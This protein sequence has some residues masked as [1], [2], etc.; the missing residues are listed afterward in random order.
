MSLS[1]LKDVDREILKS[2]DDKDLLKICGLNRKTW[3][4]VCDDN[5]LRRRITGKYPGIEKYK[6]EGESWKRFFLNAIYYISRL[7]EEFDFDYTVGDFREYYKLLKNNKE[8]GFNDLLINS[9]VLGYLPLVIYSLKH[10]ADIHTEKDFALRVAS[11]KGYLDVVKYLVE[12]GADIHR[13]DNEALLLSAARGHLEVVRYLVEQ[14]TNNESMETALGWAA[15]AGYLDVVK[16]LVERGVDIH[17]GNEYT[18]RQASKAGRLSVVKYLVEQGVNIH[19]KNDS[20]LNLARNNGH[21]EVA[22]YLSNID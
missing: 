13:F 4:E 14:G 17:S 12:H 2:V 21:I 20:A 16:Y 1:G 5:F 9:A 7:K 11:Q 15:E 8:H 18:L 10:G 22:N 6:K 19:F 3:N